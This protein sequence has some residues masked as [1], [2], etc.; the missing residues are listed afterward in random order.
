MKYGLKDI[1]VCTY[2]AISGAGKTFEMWPEMVD[3]V[4][5]FISGEEEKSE[6]EPLKIWGKLKSGQISKATGINITSQ[7]IRVP[8]TDGHMAAVFMRFADENKKPTKEQ[9]IDEWRGFKGMPQDFKL[10]TAPIVPLMYFTEE[11]FPQTAIHRGTMNGMSISLGRLRPDKQYDYKFIGLSHNTMRGA[12]GGALLM[13]E[14][15]KAQ[16]F[17]GN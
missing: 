6:T 12:A 4:I 11:N 5:P 9:I 14:L 2:Q 10:P 15:L 8:V 1:L 3:N 13:A 17:L 16:G 7:C